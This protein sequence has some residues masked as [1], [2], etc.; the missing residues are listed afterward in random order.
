MSAQCWQCVKS[1]SK[2]KFQID[3]THQSL[4]LRLVFLCFP[5][6]LTKNRKTC[7][8]DHLSR[9]RRWK[10]EE[11]EA[12]VVKCSGEA[13]SPVWCPESPPRRVRSAGRTQQ[14]VLSRTT[15]CLH[16]QKPHPPYLCTD[17][18]SFLL[19][20]QNNITPKK[21]FTLISIPAIMEF[22][23]RFGSTWNVSALSGWKFL[24]PAE[25]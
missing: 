5:F 25:I 20:E 10:R 4:Q 17:C 23:I 19:F 6:Q 1:V 22:Q 3:F 11:E 13:W 16:L 18:S 8:T 14:P 12:E 7:N 2:I 24:A 9:K 21:G 15:E